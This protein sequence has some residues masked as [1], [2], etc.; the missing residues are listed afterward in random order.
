MFDFVQT[1]VIPIIYQIEK[2]FN[3]L[4]KPKISKII[5]EKCGKV[6]KN[7]RAILARILQN[8]CNIQALIKM[9]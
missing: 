3:R 5:A 8:L 6:L 4:P 7:K 2:G 9:K 1:F